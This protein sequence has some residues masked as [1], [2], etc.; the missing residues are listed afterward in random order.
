MLVR[1]SNFEQIF[2]ME[3]RYCF[4]LTYIKEISDAYQL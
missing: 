3:K 2:L 4:I 1:K